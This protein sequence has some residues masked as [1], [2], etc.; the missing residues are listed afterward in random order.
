MA[1][2]EFCT[3]DE[4]EKTIKIN[5]GVKGTLSPEQCQKLHTYLD[6]ESDFTAVNFNNVKELPDY[7]FM[8]CKKLTKV[9]GPNIDKL[10]CDCFS[11]CAR[12]EEI[13]FPNLESAGMGCFSKT[14]LKNVTLPKLKTAY[15]F[16]FREATRLEKI[17][18]PKLEVIFPFCF[19]GCS[20]L[21]TVHVPSV[22]EVQKN[23]FKECCKLSSFTASKVAQIDDEVI[24]KLI[25]QQTSSGMQRDEIKN[26]LTKSEDG[27]EIRI[28]E[29]IKSLSPNQCL[30]IHL[31]LN[32]SP[33]YK[34]LNLAN[35][36][37]LPESALKSCRH[38]EKIIGKCVQQIGDGGFRECGELVEVSLPL[39]QKAGDHCFYGCEK[40]KKVEL[41]KLERAGVGCFSVCTALEKI[42]LP[43]L[44]KAGMSC[45]ERAS[46]LDSAILRKLQS[47]PSLCF[48]NCVR[49]TKVTIACATKIKSGAFKGCKQLNM[50]AANEEKLTYVAKDAFD[51]S[52][53]KS[54]K[55][56]ENFFTLDFVAKKSGKVK[57]KSV[58]IEDEASL[59]RP[60][61]SE[62]L[63]YEN[64]DKKIPIYPYG[65]PRPGDVYQHVYGNC[66]FLAALASLAKS[67]PRAIIDCIEDDPEN[68]KTTI[69]FYKVR[70]SGYVCVPGSRVN[71]TVPRKVLKKFP[72]PDVVEQRDID[73]SALWVQLM[74]SALGV[75]L[76][77]N[78]LKH[79]LAYGSQ[80]T[81][82]EAGAPSAAAFTM[83]TGKMSK[84]DVDIQT[85]GLKGLGPNLPASA[86]LGDPVPVLLDKSGVNKLIAQIRIRNFCA[87]VNKSSPYQP[88]FIKS[89]AYSVLGV[90]KNLTRK[91]TE[92]F[93]KIEGFRPDEKIKKGLEKIFEEVNNTVKSPYD[94]DYIILRDPHGKGGI[95]FGGSMTRPIEIRDVDCNGLILI[96]KEKFPKVFDQISYDKKDRTS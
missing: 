62:G 37:E 81:D 49:L 85:F 69:K 39:L 47:V 76:K 21:E 96:S 44:I 79:S 15:S 42:T 6:D 19:W 64:V 70:S 87:A 27:M 35:V 82:L 8:D 78:Y 12:L 88:P 52:F 5:D 28:N 53:L 46:H 7:A 61:G 80:V 31:F 90:W 17:V 22:T 30:E 86:F 67:N 33:S 63:P 89:H 93:R 74:V 54:K 58:V 72:I 16:C 11:R 59:P 77:K 57:V 13:D 25:N 91:G 71:I 68:G 29:G 1:I 9:V 95:F 65:E 10:G 2:P 26:L 43:E 92:D 51:E 36:T 60:R 45:F 14:G 84:I 40:L 41:P 55:F 34:T 83:I 73:N 18:L 48:C 24:K 66:W 3:L 94:G 75:Y 38:L 20:N 23:A 56:V 50:I 4:K 32:S